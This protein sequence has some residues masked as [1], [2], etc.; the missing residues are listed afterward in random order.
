MT[1]STITIEAE[2][3]GKIFSAFFGL[4]RLFA[5]K[6]ASNAYNSSHKIGA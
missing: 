2:K 6:F 4:R 3:S 5:D 1:R